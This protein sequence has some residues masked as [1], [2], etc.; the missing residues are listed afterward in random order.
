MKKSN[1]TLIFGNQVQQPRKSQLYREICNPM[2]RGKD[3][4]SIYIYIN[5]NNKKIKM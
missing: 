2:N 4:I 3:N 1:K 5:N